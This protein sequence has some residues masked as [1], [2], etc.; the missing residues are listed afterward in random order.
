MVTIQ[1]DHWSEIDR[2]WWDKFSPFFS[3]KELASKGDG[4]LIFSV[5]TLILINKL[6]KMYGKPLIINSAFRDAEHNTKVGGSPNSQH[7]FGTAVDIRIANHDEGRAI[8]EIAKSLDF[9]GIGRYKTFIH[10]DTRETPAEWGEW[11]VSNT[12]TT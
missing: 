8:E 12:L 10:I 2:E 4:S 11:N 5:K 3:P 6:R 9:K 1:A 7:K